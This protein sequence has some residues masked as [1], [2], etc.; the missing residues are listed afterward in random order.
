[1]PV[2][3]KLN[4]YDLNKRCY[5]QRIIIQFRAIL[6]ECCLFINFYCYLMKTEER[7][8]FENE[9]S[10]DLCRNMKAILYR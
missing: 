3:I 9:L 4:Y 8:I 5:S 1:M 10:A 6:F 7:K 2:K